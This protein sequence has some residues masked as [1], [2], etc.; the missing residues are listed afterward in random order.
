MVLRPEEHAQAQHLAW[1]GDPLKQRRVD[2][3]RK[4]TNVY[5][6]LE[7]SACSRL[8]EP[9]E[10]L[11]PQEA[12]WRQCP[13]STGEL[14]RD[15][16]VLVARWTEVDS[17]RRKYCARTPDDRIIL[18]VA[19]RRTR[20]RLSGPTGEFFSGYLA[21][22]SVH[23]CAPAQQFSAEFDAPCDFVH[24][25]IKKN[26]AD[27]VICSD[28]Y[29][30]YSSVVRCDVIC[31]HLASTLTDPLHSCDPIYIEST[32]RTILLRVKAL[33]HVRNTAVP[34]PKWRMRR[35]E[36]YIARNL[37]GPLTLDDVA[38]VAG[39]SRSYFANKFRATTGI[40]LQSYISDLR[41]EQSK[42]LLLTKMPIIQVA[43]ETG[44]QTQAHYSTVF[45]KRT[46]SSPGSWRR[47]NFPAS[48]GL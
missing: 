23:L 11:L 8:G 27:S 28:L 9:S 45:K 6:E 17:H 1:R 40:T 7:A 48:N 35:V 32:A 41:I 42:Q 26:L 22:G 18:S 10:R 46:G 47:E 37:A 33:S 24:I 16:P 4:G 25:Y 13:S 2:D 44:F 31:S 36:E 20:V 14:E 21:V 29:Y 30:N 39:L 15:A 34:L 38:A 19:L 5:D 12:S 3:R 43:L